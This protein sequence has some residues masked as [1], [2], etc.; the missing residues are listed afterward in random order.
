MKP[1]ILHIS[2]APSWRG[3]EQQLAYLVEEQLQ[4]EE[5]NAPIVVCKT[6]SPM[7]SFCERLGIET[8]PFTSKGLL[9]SKLARHIASVVNNNNISLIHT[10]D[11][12][13]HSG[14]LLANIVHNR[15]KH[16]P[17]IVSR[18]VDFPIGSSWLSRKKYEHSSVK[19][20]LC[21]SDAI[22]TIVLQTIPDEERVVTVHSGIDTTKFPD[23]H[24]IENLRQ[25]ASFRREMGLSAETPLIMNVS[26]LADHKDIP[27]FVRTAHTIIAYWKKKSLSSTLPHFVHIGKDDGEQ[28]SIFE[29]VQKLG[30]EP[31]ITFTGFRMDIP[32]ILPEADIFLFTSKTEGL[33]TSLLDAIMCHVPVVATNAGGIS[34]VVIHEKTGLL[35]DIGDVK[36]LARHT[37][38]LLGDLSLRK[39][40][41]QQALFHVQTLFTKEQTAQQTLKTYQQ[42]LTR[43]RLN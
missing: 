32:S 10:H 12:H 39:E 20:I 37:L 25:E 26:A 13:A 24:A 4:Q 21:V 34:E 33:G 6:S 35:A 38:R 28:E 9:Q 15:D 29:L 7:H 31:H 5:L 27:T 19:K 2:T 30:M 8:A 11:S 22:R 23:V 36:N 18:R 41:Q 17:L 40:V 43:Q 3:G 14:A 1:T 16:I 42:A